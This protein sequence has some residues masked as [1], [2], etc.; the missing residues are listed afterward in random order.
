MVAEILSVGTEL[1]MGQIANT[2]AMYLSR[3]LSE[4]GISLYRHVTVGDN[5]G[6]VREA[7]RA[8]LGRADLVITTGGLGPTEDDLTK[9]MV[10]AELGLA[11]ELHQPSLDQIASFFSGI[12]RAMT[13]NNAKQAMM[14]AGAIVMPNAKGTAP[15]CIVEKDG[16]LVAVLPGPPYELIDMFEQQLEP[17]LRGRS[18]REMRSRFLH[19]VGIG[20]SEVEN[21]LIDLFHS[22]NPTL[23]LYCSPGEVTA[24]VT[25]SC[26]LGGDPSGMLDAVEREV[27]RRL[28]DALYGEGIEQSLPKVALALLQQSGRTVALAESCTGGMLSSQ[29][30]DLPGASNALI[31]AH[32]VYA[33]Q[34]KVRVLGVPAELIEQYGA[35][36]E[37]C[38]AAMA[39]GAKRISGADCALSTTGIAGPGG[40]TPEKPVGT[41][42]IA[43]ATDAGTQVKRLQLRSDRTRI[44]TLTCLHAWNLLRTY[45]AR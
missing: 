23:A 9:E 7:L 15:G 42:Y 29:L 21:R 2:D 41:V 36:S 6:R 26:S 16:K 20:E 31:E 33:N 12:G 19:I 4:L 11:M 28:G 45:L 8:A 25:A 18:D 17:F 38:A 39:E 30:V 10:A 24:R 34:A 1:L 27:R 37:Q 22:D 43:L 32:V 40:G 35:V 3:R 5:P 13:P 14:P 44:R